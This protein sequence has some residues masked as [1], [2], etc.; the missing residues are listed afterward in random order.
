MFPDVGAGDDFSGA[1]EQV[2]QQPVF[3]RGERDGLTFPVNFA[4]DR[5]QLEIGHLHDGVFP[6]VLAAKQ[7]ADAGKR[8]GK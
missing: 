4:P 1:V 6:Y 5:I 2:F 7:C 3:E 8:L